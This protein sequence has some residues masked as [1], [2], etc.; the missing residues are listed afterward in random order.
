[1]P[2]GQSSGSGA[3]PV[4]RR[5]GSGS[6]EDQ[7]E[8]VIPLAAS[9]W[10]GLPDPRDQ[11]APEDCYPHG[12]PA[13]RLALT[14]PDRDEDWRSPVQMPSWPPP[15]ASLPAAGAPPGPTD[16][17]ATG[18]LDL[19]LPWTTLAGL[20]REPGHLGRLGPITSAE[21]CQLA[22]L[23][24]T[25]PATQWRIILTSSTGQALAVTR[26]PR[27]RTKPASA[28]ATTAP[29]RGTTAPPRGTTVP[30]R[31]TTAMPA[32]DNTPLAGNAPVWPN[33]PGWPG[34]P[35]GW[36]GLVGRVTLAIPPD[37]LAGAADPAISP[38]DGILGRALRAAARTAVRAAAQAAADEAA[39]G[40]AHT[41]ATPAYRPPPRLK[42]YIAVR[43]L[44]CRFPSCRQPAWRGDL[45]HTQPYDQGGMTCGCNLGGL[46]R[47]HHILK[48]HPDWQLT[49]SQPGIFQWTTPTGRRY[50]VAPEIHSI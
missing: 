31:G 33:G 8:P 4:E 30:P 47:R 24:L 12:D 5:G 16:R 22:G 11:D 7:G 1:V 10:E 36:T 38:P 3:A 37:V 27:P 40:C 42:E 41:A 23:A 20:S 6:A 34:G 19:T 29:P 44:T 2:G 9:P 49:Q 18:T 14:D 32:C 28:P 13:I 50:A 26:I 21:A 46:C 15:P 17:L 39:G 45:D 35:G 48:Q 43:D 25:S